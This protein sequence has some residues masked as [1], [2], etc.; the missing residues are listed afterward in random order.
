M[1]IVRTGI[2]TA[3]LAPLESAVMALSNPTAASATTQTAAQRPFAKLVI[4]VLQVSKPLALAAS[5][6]RFKA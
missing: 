2:V 4:S 1:S 3:M 5:M 6:L